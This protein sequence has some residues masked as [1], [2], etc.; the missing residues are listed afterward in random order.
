MSR[1]SFSRPERRF[2]QSSTLTIVGGY[3]K[4]LEAHRAGGHSLIEAEFRLRRK[5]GTWSWIRTIGKAI[6]RDASGEPTRLIG[7]HRDVTK[8]RGAQAELAAAR[9]AAD[10]ANQAKSDFLATMSHEIRTPMNGV[11]GMSVLLEDTS[12]TPEQR[13]YVRTI[14][15]SGEALVELIGDILDFSRLEAGRL[16]IERREF[17]PVSL[18]E[19][20]LEVLEPVASKKGLAIEMDIRGERV[21]RALGDPTR[22]RQVMLNL[23]G[24]AVKFTPS[25]RVTLQIVGLS[26]ER[27][28]FEVEDT[29][30]GVPEAKRHRLFEVF[31]QGDPSITRK[32]GGAGL[33]LAICKRLIEAMGGT[34]DFESRE[35]V[36][37]TFWFETPIGCADEAKAGTGGDVRRVAALLCGVERG[38]VAAQDVLA[39]CGFDLAEPE[40][41]ALIFVDTAETT[42]P[43]AGAP[44]KPILVFGGGRAQFHAPDAVLIGGALTPGRIR[45]AVEEFG[46][47]LVD[48]ER[49]ERAPEA[50][51]AGPEDPRRRGSGHQSGSARGDAAPS[52]P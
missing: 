15:Q 36:G 43:D 23:T 21:D 20:V 13:R 4:A 14:R 32:Y 34:I 27:F 10:Q 17:N 28:R 22:L 3:R 35:G 49:R 47:E 41:A 5:D 25:G 29:G 2:S 40:R 52:R 37:S 1:A 7:V 26:R 31:T 45:R 42:P 9:D 19:N 48:A 51:R 30:I 6:E 50:D 16:D 18:V 12:L 38:R 24:N 46:Q 8:T 11:I 33:G 39:Y 44:P